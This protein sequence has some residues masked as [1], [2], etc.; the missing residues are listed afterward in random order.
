MIIKTKNKKKRDFF[1]I[2][3]AYIYYKARKNWW[4]NNRGVHMPHAHIQTRMLKR[5]KKKERER[6]VI[7]SAI[8]FQ[9]SF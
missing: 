8:N 6:S 4:K 9:L 2:Y 3:V 5:I 7:E 1:F